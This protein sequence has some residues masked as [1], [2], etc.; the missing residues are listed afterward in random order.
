MPK[1]IVLATIGSLGDV[2]PFIALGLALKA[3]GYDPVIALPEDNIDKV[4]RAGLHAAGIYP[5]LQGLAERLGLDA[6]VAANRMT[7]DPDYLFRRILLPMLPEVVERLNDVAQDA[8]AIAGPVLTLAGQIVAEKRGIPFIP[9]ILQPIS[10]MSAYD[11]PAERQF[12][13]MAR[14]GTPGWRAAYNKWVLVGTRMELR[15]RYAGAINQARRGFGLA[16]TDVT[17]LFGIPDAPLV[18]ALYSDL[19]GP[20][21]PDYPPN[22]RITG[23]PVFD[24]EGGGEEQLD[25]E[26]E[27]FLSD[28]N[29]PIVFTLG[30]FA[31]HAPGDFFR[32]SIAAIRLLKRRAI[33]LTGPQAIEPEPD[34]LVRPYSPHSLVFPRSAV[35][36]HHGGVGT[37]GAALRAGRPQL[38]V[39]FMGDQPDNAAR[40]VRLGVG[41]SLDIRHY[42]ARRAAEALERLLT[43][44]TV[45]R[46]AREVAPRA[47]AENGAVKAADEIVRVLG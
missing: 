46:R 32:Q 44:E 4:R 41:A 12:W 13:M 11:P 40:I 9:C 36:V 23:F 1:K 24:S 39:P 21:Q 5:P 19:L 2:H 6:V 43:D 28:R 42:S 7:R 26:L 8:V 18:L 16:K 3:R 35:N 17:P 34:V 45:G 33:L 29:P 38:V 27:A 30:S 20:Q 14:P 22:T 47:S 25:P 31:V 37:T 15:R 10:M